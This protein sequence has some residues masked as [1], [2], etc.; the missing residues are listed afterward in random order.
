MPTTVQSGVIQPH[1]DHLVNRIASPQEAEAIRSRL[2]GL[3]SVRLSDRQMS[4]LEMIAIGGFSPLQGFM[5]SADYG[6]VVQEMHLASGLPW[7]M[8]ITLAVATEEAASLPVGN[9][10][11]LLSPDGEPVGVLKLEEKYTYDKALEARNVYRTEDEAHPGVAVVYQ[12]GDVLL[13]GAV[14]VIE[15]RKATAFATYRLDPSETRA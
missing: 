8:P 4:D 11:A 6:R 15:R 13:G 9:E 3:A 7:S 5:T 14:T 10:I 1:G 2:P 12:Q